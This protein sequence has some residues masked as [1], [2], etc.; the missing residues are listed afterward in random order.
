MKKWLW[1]DIEQDGR[2]RF[3][4]YT[5]PREGAHRVR[6]PHFDGTTF[7][8]R[9]KPLALRSVG[10]SVEVESDDLDGWELNQIVLGVSASRR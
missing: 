10:L 6:G 2:C 8:Q 7:E 9:R 1:V 4:F 3:Y 5:D